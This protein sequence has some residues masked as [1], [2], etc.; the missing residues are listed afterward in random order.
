MGN[1]ESQ[2]VNYLADSQCRRLEI[3]PYV[4]ILKNHIEFQN[5]ISELSF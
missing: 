2:N 3:S 4:N 5:S 1:W